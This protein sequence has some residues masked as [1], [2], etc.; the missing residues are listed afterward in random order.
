[1]NRPQL[2]LHRAAVQVDPEVLSDM[3]IP[4]EGIHDGSKYVPLHNGE[5]FENVQTLATSLLSSMTYL[6]AQVAIY[7]NNLRMFGVLQFQDPNWETSCLSIGIRNSYDAS[8]R[9]GVCVGDTVFV[10][11]NLAF[12][13]QVTIARRHTGNVMEDLVGRLTIPLMRAR[14]TWMSYNE[15]VAGLQHLKMGDRAAYGLLGVA[16][17]EQVLPPTIFNEAIRQWDE[18]VVTGDHEVP[19]CLSH[20]TMYRLHQAVLGAMKGIHPDLCIPTSLKWNKL[21]GQY[22]TERRES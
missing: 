7:K 22:A 17:G 11:D 10:C 20:K 18:P 2:I 8:C 12:T 4:T 15:Q 14:N 13:G 6:G 21:A 1:M 5:F 3:P 19:E 16:A 9:A